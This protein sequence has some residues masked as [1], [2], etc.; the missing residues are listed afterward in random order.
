[1]IVPSS[2]NSLFIHQLINENQIDPIDEYFDIER[3]LRFRST[4]PANLYRNF[5][6]SGNRKTWTWSAWIKRGRTYI[7]GASQTTEVLFGVDDPQTS[8]ANS[9]TATI[10]IQ[11]DQLMFAL[12]NIVVRWTNRFLR[13]T[14]AW[15]H[16]IVVHDTTNPNADDR[17][18]IYINGEK[19]TSFQTSTYYNNLTLNADYGI[20][21]AAGHTLGLNNGLV[22]TLPA[23]QKWEYEGY[24]AEVNFIDGQ[25]LL[26]SDFG[27]FH[28]A[29]NQ[30]RPKKFTGSY[31]LNGFY[32]PF[33]DNSQLTQVIGVPYIF[34]QT[35]SNN[36][37]NYNL[38]TAALAGGWNG[39]APLT[40]TITIDSGV[41]VS[42]SSSSTP[43]FST[44]TSA[45][46]IGSTLSIINNGSIYGRGGNGGIGADATTYTSGSSATLGKNGGNAIDVRIP[47]SITNAG[48]IFAGGGG[49]NGGSATGG[50]ANV[51]AG[52]GGGG[53][54]AGYPG[55][56]GGTASQPYS[57][58]NYP[59]GYDGSSG[60]NSAGGSGGEGVYSGFWPNQYSSPWFARSGN[61]G[62]GGNWGEDS[63]LNN[64][65]HYYTNGTSETGTVGGKGGY[66][67]TTY[68]Y[69]FTWISGYNTN[70]VKG[71]EN[72]VG[73][74]S[75]GLTSDYSGNANHFTSTGISL[76]SGYT[77]DS[78][79][80]T[81]TNNFSLCNYYD[82][83]ND[84]T[85]F[86]W[87]YQSGLVT[88]A[89]GPALTNSW[90]R[91]NIWVSS[92]KWYAE[93]TVVT[94]NLNGS[95]G[96]G[97]FAGGVGVGR[98]IDVNST[99]SNSDILYSNGSMYHNTVAGAA[100][101]TGFFAIGTVIGLLLDLDN[102]T[103][104]MYRDGVSLGVV[105]TGLSGRHAFVSGGYGAYWAMNFGQQ[106]FKYELPIGY[107]TLSS[108][109][110]N[111]IIPNPEKYFDT[112]TYI[113]TG[114]GLQ[115]GE[116]QKPLEL[117]TIN[118]S[119]A[120]DGVT[121]FLSKTSVSNSYTKFT[122]SG[123]IKRSRIVEPTGLSIH[124]SLF[125]QVDTLG[126][127]F[128]I[129]ISQGGSVSV[130]AY[131]NAL[132]LYWGF[133]STVQSSLLNNWIHVCVNIDT[134]LSVPAERIIIIV[135]GIKLQADTIYAH[136][137]QNSNIP[138]LGNSS[139][140]VRL[141]L[142][143]DSTGATHFFSGKMA[144]IH[145]VYDVIPYT[146]FG[147]YDNKGYWVPK[148]FSGDHGT[149]G[150]YLTFNDYTGVTASTLGKDTSGN[151]NNIL[152][153]GFSLTPGYACSITDDTPSNNFA[154]W[155]LP[156]IVS[157]NSST[158]DAGATILLPAIYYGCSANMEIDAEN[159][160]GWF[161]EISTVAGP[162]TGATNTHASGLVRA[163]NSLAFDDTI[164]QGTQ[165]YIIVRQTGLVYENTL[166]TLT[167]ATIAETDVIGYCLKAGKL[168]V[169]KNGVAQNSGNP[170]ASNL[171][172]SWKIFAQNA[173]STRRA[174]YKLN[175][176]ASAFAYPSAKPSSAM[177]ICENN[178]SEYNLDIES[179]D[180]IWIKSRSS[181]TDNNLYFR[182]SSSDNIFTQSGTYIVPD[183]VALVTITARG[184][185]G[186]GGGG[187]AIPGVDVYAGGG[188]GS[189][190]VQSQTVSVTPGQVI[191]FTIGSGGTSSGSTQ[192]GTGGTTTVTSTGISITAAGGA[193][194][195]TPS[196]FG[197]A[198]GGS[199]QYSGS[200]G[201]SEYM[202][203]YQGGYGAGTG[204]NGQAYVRGGPGSTGF[205]G[206]IGFHGQPYDYGAG[207]G[208]GGDLSSGA[209]AM[210]YLGG[211]GGLGGGGG[212]GGLGGQA[213]GLGGKGYVKIYDGKVKSAPF[214]YLVSNSTAPMTTVENSLIASN[215]NGFYI[216]NFS[217]INSS[218]ES[219]VA[220]N[221]KKGTTPGFD[222]VTYA[223]TGLAQ[224]I[225]HS[226]GAKPKLIIAKS[227]S[228][229]NAWAVGSDELGTN[230]NS[231]CILNTTNAMTTGTMWNNSPP[232]AASFSVGPAPWG[233]NEVG[234]SN[235]AFLFAEVEGFSKFGKYKG[236]GT[237]KGPF[238]YCGFRPAYLMIK[239]IDVSGNW[240]I[241]DAARD[242]INDSLIN[243]SFV[244]TTTVETNDA[245]R[246]IDFLAN[247]FK[248]RS[249]SVVEFNGSNATYLYIAF[250][251]YPF[252]Y[253]N[254]K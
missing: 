60:T 242:V 214:G 141:G 36:T 247:G 75:V 184:G 195:E 64:A 126:Q 93:A 119:L 80:D 174:I 206:G 51:L 207:G 238:I 18:R 105:A 178:L 133:K 213:G 116:T 76:S 185:G 137:I 39:T 37:T 201:K 42:S 122:Y 191:N 113:G 58:D 194:G 218:G 73:V 135:N 82:N 114:H 237:A 5:A 221:W 231:Y 171:Q 123:W 186:G 40:A 148:T 89:T 143:Y 230:W 200:I 121:S 166:Q 210:G 172:G 78:M 153:T 72:Y 163:S 115:V 108:K 245:N 111:A 145:V 10:R 136:P 154:N 23:G 57:G 7:D 165:D 175:L 19:E 212:G 48:N 24:M 46:P 25:A 251:E 44:G 99:L 182:N 32:L 151:G 41:I 16:I 1:M 109:N 188:G 250:A 45:F 222:I 35:I 142:G 70:Q 97:I 203:R 85:N 27:G 127:G 227:T 81:P 131:S 63:S 170:I 107:N 84:G 53:G 87:V 157:T 125:N 3:S 50:I 235:V 62:N 208:G 54:G 33:S 79:L 198:A 229:G 179:P 183:N 56:T 17:L 68:G 243:A 196:G 239:R 164:K 193:G 209:D 160:N 130:S 129:N 12:S 187:Y 139:Y 128:G 112:K 71:K 180:L 156:S 124:D 246:N 147:Q 202:V 21:R 219:Y 211:A 192:G 149:D 26:P 88:C 8:G 161:W 92:G 65:G 234:S 98:E 132:S 4:A 2:T 120:F 155:D 14:S 225:E 66:A 138:A 189:G 43:A 223:G 162:G 244:N 13:D 173:F 177:T 11:N 226:L 158:S 96:S 232:S 146:S 199:G 117:F 248:I 86:S 236:N 91:S 233:I 241:L 94:A 159:E 31:G 49:G 47:T 77:Y 20:N 55:G 34:N 254:A 22:S 252:R 104:T 30:W 59:K 152:P 216:G 38:R 103:L 28:Y 83:Y 102:G 29:T 95:W 215:K 15:Y 168:Y 190:Y 205:L 204:G 228:N 169:W 118:K 253:A 140:N 106:P 249:G 240:Q 52:G 74:G 69:N 90:N 176:G 224:T 67:I 144:D 197:T 167:I 181:T 217:T 220:W 61:G 101:T 110:I 6:T 134:T 150:F 100:V 9:T